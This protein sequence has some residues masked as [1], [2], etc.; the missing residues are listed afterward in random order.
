[1]NSQYINQHNQSTV[2]TVTAI[3]NMLFKQKSEK[4][5]KKKKKHAHD[6]CG[7]GKD[8]CLFTWCIMT[9]TTQ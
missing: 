4:K 3:S 7:C 8:L 6:V 5:K 1:M 2:E 9:Q